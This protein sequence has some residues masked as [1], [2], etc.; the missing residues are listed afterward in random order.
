L[1]L[2]LTGE[3]IVVAQA[4]ANRWTGSTFYA[5]FLLFPWLEFYIRG[6]KWSL[7]CCEMS[8]FTLL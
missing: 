2:K 4:S 6:E 5:F 7:S 8:H 3:A 1:V